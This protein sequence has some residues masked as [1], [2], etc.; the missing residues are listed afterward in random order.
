MGSPSGSSAV[1][2]I[3]SHGPAEMSVGDGLMGA[4]RRSPWCRG[5]RSHSRPGFWS[6]YEAAAWTII[7]HRIRITQAAAITARIAERP[8]PDLGHAAA[9]GPAGV[10]DRRDHR[11]AR[12]RPDGLSWGQHVVASR[13]PPAVRQAT[14]TIRAAGPG[15]SDAATQPGA[16][17]PWPGPG[18]T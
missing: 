9:A 4:C 8:V 17:T 1:L 5:G 3:A 12:S 6:P 15:P 2:A 10:L 18:N 16:S 11:Q 14:P 13:V 7:G